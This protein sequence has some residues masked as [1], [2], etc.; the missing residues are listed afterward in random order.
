LYDFL[1]R[2]RSAGQLK[3]LKTNLTIKK[4]VAYATDHFCRTGE[5]PHALTGQIEGTHSDTWAN[6][7]HALRNGGRGFAGGSSL[8]A[9]FD[10]FFPVEERE[11]ILAAKDRADVE[12]L[13]DGSAL[14]RNVT[15]KPSGEAN[16]D[17]AHATAPIVTDV[18]DPTVEPLQD[19][20]I[21]DRDATTQKPKRLATKKQAVRSDETLSTTIKGKGGRRKL[22]FSGLDL[23]TVLSWIDHHKKVEGYYPLSGSGKVSDDS[24]YTWSG[25]DKALKTGT[26]GD[27]VPRSLSKLIEHRRPRKPT[28]LH[29]ITSMAL[30]QT[31][32]VTSSQ[33]Q[34]SVAVKP[35]EAGQVVAAKSTSE[36]EIVATHAPVSDQGHRGSRRLRQIRIDEK[37]IRHWIDEYHEATGTYPTIASGKIA[38]VPTISWKHIAKVLE[39]GNGDDIAPGGSLSKFIFMEYGVIGGKVVAPRGA[40]SHHM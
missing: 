16:G 22:D 3:P 30:P 28:Q 34:R 33:S 5:V 6:I 20:Q 8:Q 37:M 32:V 2:H 1:E 29:S 7:E 11:A 9:I 17:L 10:E 38:S 23:E 21:S 12:A 39:Q 13:A 25:I 19:R 27:D 24:P 15:A 14:V 40:T 31:T 35:I 4:I 26:F 36:Q 18:G